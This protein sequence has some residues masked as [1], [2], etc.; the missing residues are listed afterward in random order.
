MKKRLGDRL[1]EK[2]KEAKAKFKE[3]SKAGAY[4]SFAPGINAVRYANEIVAGCYRKESLKE[5]TKDPRS[6][7]LINE[8]INKYIDCAR[9]YEDAI[10]GKTSVETAM[11]GIFILDKM[12]DPDIED[13][14]I[15]VMD[16]RPILGD[17]IHTEIEKYEE[18]EKYGPPK[19]RGR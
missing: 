1:H 19:R 4:S 10:F 13:R 14:L 2:F 5:L 6:A 12:D 17:V 8:M 7:E 18:Y 11:A 3:E 16:K 15:D 9:D